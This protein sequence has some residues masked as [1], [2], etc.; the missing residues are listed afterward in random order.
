MDPFGDKAFYL[1]VWHALLAG[2]VAL[3]LMVLYSAEPAVAFLI[4][5]N[6]ALLFALAL[7][8]RARQLTADRIERSEPWRAL[9]PSERP[10]G[11]PGRRWAARTFEE[12]LLRFA[13]GAAGAAI[14]LAG[15]ALALANT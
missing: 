15:S 3:V 9:N 14:A 11:A 13:K 10:A 2:L 4:G 7:M 6:V 12:L 8:L 5:A 1:T